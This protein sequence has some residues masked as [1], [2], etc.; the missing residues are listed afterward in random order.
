MTYNAFE[1]TCYYS[2]TSFK[3]C[4]IV[5]MQLATTKLLIYIYEAKTTIL[6]ATTLDNL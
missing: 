5:H 4:A 3:M 2:K 1:N 6:G